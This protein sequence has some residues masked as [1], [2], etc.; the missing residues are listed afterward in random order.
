MNA[1]GCLFGYTQNRFARFGKPTRAG[2]HAF[3][4]LGKDGFF[5]FR[6]RNFDQ[7]NFACLNTRA[8]Q[9]VERR[10]A[11]IVQDQIGTF[12]EHEGL[13]E[14]IPMLNQRLAFDG[15]Y[16]NPC[17][18]DRRSSVILGRENITRCPAHIGTQSNQRFDK[19]RGLDGHVQRSNDPGTFQRLALAELVAQ[20]HQARHFRFSDIQLFAAKFGQR[21][22]F[23]GIIC[24][25]EP[26]SGCFIRWRRA[27]H[28]RNAQAT[29][30]NQQSKLFMFPLHR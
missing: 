14:V 5:F 18:R 9:H 28:Y 27:Y 3:L 23:D 4:D 21:N 24:S 22:V 1:G 25:H 19:N 2:G 20:R 8:K 7:V 12:W 17:F 26:A 15:E 6:S 10:V 13:I 29:R 16:R 11:T 30:I